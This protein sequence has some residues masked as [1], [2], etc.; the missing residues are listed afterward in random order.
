M[1]RTSWLEELAYRRMPCPEDADWADTMLYLSFSALYAY[2]QH[3]GLSRDQGQE[4][5]QRIL[6]RYHEMRVREDRL[7]KAMTACLGIDAL[8]KE[9]RKIPDLE[10]RPVLVDFIQIMTGGDADGEKKQ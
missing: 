7:D 4:L 8:I 2:A 9:L 1:D 6:N 3:G 5:K 10:Q